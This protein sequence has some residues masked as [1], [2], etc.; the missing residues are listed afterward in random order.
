[1]RT[2]HNLTRWLA[3]PARVALGILMALV[4]A[5]VGL[6][7]AAAQNG[8]L[9]VPACNDVLKLG[10]AA[11]DSCLRVVNAGSP[12]AGP[13]DVYLGDQKIVDALEYGKATDFVAVPSESQRLRVVG[14]GAAVDQA[15]FDWTENLRPGAAYQMTISGLERQ[16][17]SPWLSGVDVST[18]PA[19]QA[20]VRVVNAS[21]DTGPVDVAVEGGR[22]PFAGIDLGSQSGYVPFNAGSFKFELRLSGSDTL[23]VTTPPVQ[24]EEGKNYDLYVMG[25]SKGGTLA[26]VIFP[27]DVGVATNVTPAANVTPVIA[28]G[29]TPVLVTPA[30]QTP[31]PTPTS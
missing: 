23:M 20:R 22:T 24:I 31:V 3:L 6:P 9:A 17:L 21:P 4:L 12:Q 19:G 15:V 28:V 26:L 29:A 10:Q 16:G 11:T 8:N 30:A 25:L 2:M 1:M 7:V 27:T 5:G 18:L 13:V 14:A